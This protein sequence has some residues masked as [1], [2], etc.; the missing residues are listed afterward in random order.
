MNSRL[1]TLMDKIDD[2]IFDAINRFSKYFSIKT[3]K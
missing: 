1:S 2:A 3:R